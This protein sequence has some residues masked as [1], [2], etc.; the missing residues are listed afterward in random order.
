MHVLCTEKNLKTWWRLFNKCIFCFK[1]FSLKFIKLIPLFSWLSSVVKG[2]IVAEPN[3]LH[4]GILGF[5]SSSEGFH[6]QVEMKAQLLIL[7][8]YLV[9]LSKG[10]VFWWKDIVNVP[11]AILSCCLHMQGL[12]NGRSCTNSSQKISQRQQDSQWHFV[13]HSQLSLLHYRTRTI[14][15]LEKEQDAL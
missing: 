6:W 9:T 8:L 10:F 1:L 2:E 7:L 4:P 15:Q 12:S 5:K 3:I 11:K 13:M 14:F